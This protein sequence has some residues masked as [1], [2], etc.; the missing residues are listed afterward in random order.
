[1]F[2]LSVVLFCFINI[3]PLS[4]SSKQI[5]ILQPLSKYYYQAITT[6]FQQIS[7]RN[8]KCWYLHI[9]DC[10]YH[11]DY[12]IISKKPPKQKQKQNKK[13]QQPLYSW[14]LPCQA[15]AISKVACTRILYPLFI[16]NFSRTSHL[17]NNRKR[18][19]VLYC[20]LFFLWGSMIPNV[21]HWNCTQISYVTYQATKTK[22]DIFM[23]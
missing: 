9:T 1:M 10:I 14:R 21:L 18:K 19:L 17:N 13:Q 8:W 23:K 15:E 16:D 5:L 2:S 7:H 12:Y 11:Y 20:F 3:F 6:K 22:I 4:F